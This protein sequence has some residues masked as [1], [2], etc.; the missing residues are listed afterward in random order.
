ME[1]YKY[2]DHLTV[3][4]YIFEQN[5]SRNAYFLPRAVPSVE[6]DN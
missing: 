5:Q 1:N 4:V 2:K 3:T 6:S